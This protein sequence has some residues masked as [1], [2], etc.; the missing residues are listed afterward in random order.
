MLKN[1]ELWILLKSICYTY[2]THFIE[3]VEPTVTRATFY[4]YIVFI[5]I[6][7][8]ILRY[9]SYTTVFLTFLDVAKYVF[10][11]S[12]DITWAM[13]MA[14]IHIKELP[15]YHGI[16]DY[17]SLALIQ[18]TDLSGRDFVFG[19]YTLHNNLIYSLYLYSQYSRL[20]N[21]IF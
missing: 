21:I 16:S 12:Y 3:Q 17:I 5:I 8:F 11:F 9:L 6:S 10:F 18:I 15:A 19:A 4:D 20:V 13:P 7:Y 2:I 14:G 1:Q